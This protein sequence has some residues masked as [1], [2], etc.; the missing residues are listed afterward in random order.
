MTYDEALEKLAAMGPEMAAKG[1]AR[2]FTLAHIRALL[3]ALENPQKRFPAV[4]IAGT[5][6]KGSTAATLASIANAAVLRTGL[7]TSPHLLRV[8]ERIRVSDGVTLAEIGDADFARVFAAVDERARQLVEDEIL[9]HYPSFFELLTA[10]GFVYFAEREVELA[11]LE[12][13]LG[14]RLDA[15]NSVEPMVSV[16]T[17]IALDHMDYLGNTLPEIAREKAGILRE[18]GVLV[19]LSQHP[20]ANQAIGEKAME[21]NVRG[22][23]AA[24]FLPPMKQGIG[25]R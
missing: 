9:P 19:T 3:G 15:T 10:I 6:G 2:K 8:N 4:L 25:N 21:R 12:V 7:Y 14:E 11:V 23:D 5:N 24:R 22:V 13:G 20:Q 1:A 17:D 18:N 16:I